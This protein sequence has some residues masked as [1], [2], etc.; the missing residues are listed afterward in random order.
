MIIYFPSGK[1]KRERGRASYLY[2]LMGNKDVLWSPDP[3]EG[4]A[5][6]QQITCNSYYCLFLKLG[7]L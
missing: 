5:A 4:L 2:Y 6:L 3:D 7:T 1:R